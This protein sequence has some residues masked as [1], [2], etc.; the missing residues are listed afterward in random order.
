MIPPK[1]PI[2]EEEYEEVREEIRETADE[3]IDAMRKAMMDVARNVDMYAPFEYFLQTASI[4][5]QPDIIAATD[6]YRFYVGIPFLIMSQEEKRFVVIH[7]L[8]HII[9]G[10][11]FRVGNRDRQLWNIAADLINNSYILNQ[12]LEDVKMPDGALYDPKYSNMIR[13]S[14]YDLIIQMCKQ[15]GYFEIAGQKIPCELLKDGKG[16]GGIKDPLSDDVI[17][18]DNIDDKEA[19]EKRL[20]ESENRYREE[21]GH[22][23]WLRDWIDMNYAPHLPWQS[24]I[25]QY[26]QRIAASDYT[27]RNPK[28]LH[29][30]TKE[31]IILPRLRQKTVKIAIAIDT[32]GSIGQVE[33]NMFVREMQRLIS[34]IFRSGTLNG[35]LMLTTDDVYSII[36][37]PPIPTISEIKKKVK[38]GGTSFIPAFE[39]IKKVMHDDIDLLV[40]FTDGYGD[41]PKWRPKYSVLWVVTT[42]IE[43][44]KESNNYPPFGRVIEL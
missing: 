13:E 25:Q 44:L 34:V 43:K 10:D 14:L 7:E 36:K 41:Y 33:A 1:F 6:G 24:I 16:M 11:S 8:W 35:V 28:Q 4:V 37:I 31:P 21:H 5:F 22:G 39:Y 17:P 30:I 9:A 2:D 38:S 18:N 15:Y 42:K 29:G 27:W 40:Y 12:R 20:K 19:T 26:L 32:S 3:V 23:S